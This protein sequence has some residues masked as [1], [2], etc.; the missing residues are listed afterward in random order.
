[1]VSQLTKGERQLAI[2]G[3]CL[4]GLELGDPFPGRRGGRQA[5]AGSTQRFEVRALAERREPIAGLHGRRDDLSVS[6]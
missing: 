5:R 6:S 1:M 4:L 3:L 2:V